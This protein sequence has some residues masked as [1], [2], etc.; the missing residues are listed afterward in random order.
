[1]NPDLIAESARSPGEPEA[2]GLYAAGEIIGTRYR[3]CTGAPSAL[4]DLV[5]GWLAARDA[6][7]HRD[8]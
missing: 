1:M 4:Q 3:T 7:R 6:A 8:A 5:F 2:A